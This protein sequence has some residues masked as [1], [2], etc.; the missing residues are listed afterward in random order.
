M[1][2][3]VGGMKPI[4]A[5]EWEDNFMKMADETFAKHEVTKTPVG[6]S[7]REPKSFCHAGSIVLLDWDSILVHGDL[8]DVLYQGGH[9][10]KEPEKRLSWLAS[11][12][13]D[14]VASKVRLGKSREFDHQIALHDA[15]EL[16]EGYK[17][18]GTDDVFGPDST[19][20][21][22]KE[23]Y[24]HLLE[25]ISR[26]DDR[27]AIKEYLYE[28]SEGD[29]ELCSGLGEAIHTDVIWTYSAVKHVWEMVKAGKVK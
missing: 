14:Y 2:R 19:C 7:F 3:L 4:S 10:Y 5:K 13:L 29:A 27:H 22:S 23:D 21:F 12:N 16:L 8:P 6:W 11:G 26:E 24:E 28:M 25:K 1:V 15:H 20:P 17:N 18:D 9:G